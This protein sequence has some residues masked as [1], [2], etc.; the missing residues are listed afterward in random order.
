MN[1]NQTIFDKAVGNP[2]SIKQI[3]GKGF[4]LLVL[5][6]HL[7]QCIL[8]KTDELLTI[9][10]NDLMNEYNSNLYKK[11]KMVK[12]RKNNILFET[13]IKEVSSAG[14]LLTVDATERQ[15]DFGE[16]EWVI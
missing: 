15:F 7:R 9:S 11:E 16:V 3:T 1:I 4:D 10:F 6:K 5:A 8:K 2:V 13:L 14:Q 12:L